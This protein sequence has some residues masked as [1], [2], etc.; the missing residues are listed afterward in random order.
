VEITRI[1]F[2]VDVVAIDYTP[3]GE[4]E[5]AGQAAYR[6]TT[7][8]GESAPTFYTALT[9]NEAVNVILRGLAARVPV[10]FD[11]D[12]TVELLLAAIADS[13]RPEEET[14]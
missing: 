11:R 3:P 14:P 10:S 12:V 9:R 4:P 2:T 13:Q 8:Y 1:Q 6:V 7:R 5:P